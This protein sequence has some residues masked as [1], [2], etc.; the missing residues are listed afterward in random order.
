MSSFPLRQ[1]RGRRGFTLVELAAVTAV[2]FALSLLIVLAIPAWPVRR[3]PSARQGNCMSNIKALIQ[4]G[5]MYRDDFRVC[6][7]A[8]YGISYDGTNLTPRL[9]PSY[10]RDRET[11]VCSRS[12]IPLRSEPRI[13]PAVNQ[14]SGAVRLVAAFSSYEAQLRNPDSPRA[15]FELHYSPCWSGPDSEPDSRQLAFREPSDDA[16]VTWCLYH[17]LSDRRTGAVEP[18]KYALVGF[19]DGR[20]QKLPAEQLSDWPDTEGRFPWQ[21]RPRP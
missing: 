16:V 6:P 4:G 19:W 1:D 2:L 8:L 14:T 13:V 12:P 18:G 21:V 3:E 7:D 11:F 15:T 17:A 5:K 9:Y 10:V 20:V